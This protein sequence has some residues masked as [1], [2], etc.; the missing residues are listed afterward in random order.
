MNTQRN[1]DTVTFSLTTAAFLVAA[2]AT[3][4]YVGFAS[5]SPTSAR[6]AQDEQSVR[7]AT[8]QLAD[9]STKFVVT[10]KRVAA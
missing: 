9:G 2:V 3:M 5:L 10:A 6:V 4:G 1:L 7:V 8:T